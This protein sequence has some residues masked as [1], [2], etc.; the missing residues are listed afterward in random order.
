MEKPDIKNLL[1][2]ECI[3]VGCVPPALY[4][5]GSGGLSD[6]PSLPVYR[7]TPVKIL[8]CL[9]LRLRVVKILIHQ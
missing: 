1:E 6:T 5:K 3:Q 4:R 8:P 9:K 2:Q 7:Q